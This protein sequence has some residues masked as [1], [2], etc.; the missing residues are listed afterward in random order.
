[1]S[2]LEYLLTYVKMFRFFPVVVL[3]SYLRLHT[4][5]RGIE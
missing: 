4:F 1:M 2:S 3:G 5:M